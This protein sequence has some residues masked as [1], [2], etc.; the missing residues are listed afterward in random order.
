LLFVLDIGFISGAQICIQKDF[1]ASD[2]MI[3][4]IVSALLWGAVYSVR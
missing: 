1:G 4:L 2:Q 3:E